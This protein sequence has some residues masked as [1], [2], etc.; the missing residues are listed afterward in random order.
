MEFKKYQELADSTAGVFEESERT[1]WTLITAL[2]LAGEAGEVA[3]YLKKVYG[4]GHTLDE[5]K[6]K[7][8]LGDVLWYLADMCTKFDFSLNEVALLNIEKLKSRYP[9]GFD[10]EKSKNRQEGD[11]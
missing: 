11:V 6:L 2:G 4:H 5:A 9:S 10:F 7:K 8:E 3:D 1:H